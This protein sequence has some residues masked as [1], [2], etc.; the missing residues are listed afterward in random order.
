MHTDIPN[1]I[2]TLL[3][4]GAVFLLSL[5]L[6][7][8]AESS[9]SVPGRGDTPVTAPSATAKAI[10]RAPVTPAQF[11]AN[12]RMDW[13]GVM[14][15]KAMD[16]LRAEIRIAKPKDLCKVLERLAMNADLAARTYT[17]LSV[18]KQNEIRK[19]V[20]AEVGCR[21]PKGTAR[22]ASHD[23]AGSLADWRGL[24]VQASSGGTE[25]SPEARELVNRIMRANQ[26]SP[27]PAVLATELADITDEARALTDDEASVIEA[28]A[29]VALS[30][31][32]YWSA[33]AKAMAG[34]IRDAYGPCLA[35]GGRRS[36]VSQAA[37][38][39]MRPESAATIQLVANQQ[40]IE[41]CEIH[42]DVI[43]SG[44]VW[45]AGVGLTI[46]LKYGGGIAGALIGLF[47]GALLGSGGGATY[48]LVEYV[49]CAYY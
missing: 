26:G 37:G 4:T 3:T 43:W 1:R 28:V 36:C 29:S 21:G 20:F 7:A 39:S 23:L 46:G 34:E 15:N 47:G 19:A 41:V 9:S 11:H 27:S 33:N 25:F 22:N 14:H 2:A 44:D 31:L 6:G 48:E 24:N 38:P 13:A 40:D 30:S 12:N 18:D 5:A 16:E 10:P 45:G 8:C 42:V 17:K 49:I 35:R 32:E